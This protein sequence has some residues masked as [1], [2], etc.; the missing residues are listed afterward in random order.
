MSADK[1]ELNAE[2]VGRVKVVSSAPDLPTAF[3]IND[4]DFTN[5]LEVKMRPLVKGSINVASVIEQL[6][7]DEHAALAMRLCALYTFG[8]LV[9]KRE[10]G[11]G[12]ADGM[13]IVGGLQIPKEIKRMLREMLDKEDD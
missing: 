9:E 13:K 3:G 2:S 11:G 6:Y 5:Y 4:A 10:S 7:N 1:E 8:R 12:F